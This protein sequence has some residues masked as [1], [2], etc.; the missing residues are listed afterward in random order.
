MHI[1]L[2]IHD[3]LNPKRP[4]F[5]EA[6]TFEQRVQITHNAHISDYNKSSLDAQ[7]IFKGYR[8]RVG[9]MGVH[10]A[11]FQKNCAGFI[12]KINRKNCQ[13]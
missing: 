4:K 3:R 10:V 13:N 5:L 12:S 1:I 9:K 6:I 2:C 11:F 8:T 7:T